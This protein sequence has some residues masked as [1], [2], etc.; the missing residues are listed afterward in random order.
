MPK[1]E[2]IFIFIQA[3][4]GSS[5][6]PEKVIRD[7][8]G[9]PL[10]S[11]CIRRLTKVAPVL[12]ATSDKKE[13][14]AIEALAVQE[15][16]RCFRGSEPDV[17]DRFYRAAIFFNAKYIIRATGDNPF[18][19]AEEA[20]RIAECLMGSSADYVTGFEVVQGDGLPVGVGVEG[21][22]FDA[23]KRSWNE[24]HAPHH[25]EHVNEYILENPES[26]SIKRLK[27][28]AANSCSN[29]RLTVDTQDDFAFAQEII[30]NMNKPPTEIRTEEII[31]WW[32][33]KNLS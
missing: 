25:R 10:L 22:S 26:F 32:Q 4:T 28:Q 8:G 3:R 27:C 5:R 16:V 15:N 9:I 23:L 21:F 31:E 19:D 14:N 2:A 11:H 29:L 30:Q 18:V 7:L 33:K 1:E 13:D 17:L 6:L 24:G 20:K 12:V